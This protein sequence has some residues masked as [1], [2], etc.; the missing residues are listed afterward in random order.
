MKK[1]FMGAGLAFLLVCLS[2]VVWYHHFFN[3]F[4]VDGEIHIGILDAPV[5]VRRDEYGIPYISATNH[6]DLIRAQGFIAAQDRMFQIEMYRRVVSGQLAELIGDKGIP[7]D[8]RS[9]VSGYQKAAEKNVSALSSRAREF[10]SWYAEGLNAFIETRQHEF[11]AE[12]KLMGLDEIQPWTLA[13]MLAFHYFIGSIHGTNARDEILA[14]AIR[15]ELGSE[16]L[17]LLLP[18]NQNPDRKGPALISGYEGLEHGQGTDPESSIQFGAFFEF[19]AE[20]PPVFGS[21]NW[22]IAP[23]K[24]S[25]G[26]AIVASDPHLDARQLPGPMYPVGLFAPGINAIGITMAGLPGLVIGRT[27]HVAYGATNG[28]GDSQDTYLE[29]LDTDKPGHYLEGD[30]SRAFEVSTETIRVK[31]GDSFIDHPIT[32]RNTRRGPVISDHDVFGIKGGVTLTLRYPGLEKQASEIGMDRFLTAT[33]A[34]E[35]DQAVQ[36]IDLMYFNFVFADKE[37][38]IGHRAS[39]LIPVRIQGGAIPREARAQDNWTG[40]IPKDQMPGS[41]NPERNW[42][43][44]ANHD[45]RPDDYPYYYSSHFA[46]DYRY[47]RIV[48]AMTSSESMSAEQNW[49][50]A[51]DTRNMLA[52]KLAPRM[53]QWLRQDGSM[54]QLADI[55]E[56]WDFRDETDSVGA[57][58]FHVIYEQLPGLVFKDDMPASLADSFLRSRYFIQQRFDNALLAGRSPWFD[59]QSTPEVETASDLVIRAGHMALRQIQETLGTDPATWQWGRANRM[60][61]VSPLRQKGFGRDWLGGGEHPGRGSHE[62][63]NRAGYTTD[64]FPYATAY[65]ASARLVADFSDDEKV[66]ASLPGGIVARQGHPWFASQLENYLTGGWVPWWRSEARVIEHA[67]HVLELK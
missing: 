15:Q 13:D 19:G 34:R 8:T 59:D 10:L 35:F 46:P 30:L 44:T 51:N 25:S 6:A 36:D 31:Q 16:A 63:L 60:L 37:G 4:Q 52:V 38:N 1:W 27:D 39:G 18:V 29:V 17:N 67:Q 7:S 49:D 55:L 21:N 2:A 3:R 24:S 14:L 66:M 47:A 50:L 64:H 32:V 22:A 45:T 20:A 57:T 61:F 41:F 48:E 42:L 54:A 43:G 53:A 12:L 56:S 65:I 40:W 28:Y 26:H 23:Q 58:V 62:T 11:P 5:T 33:S 9:R